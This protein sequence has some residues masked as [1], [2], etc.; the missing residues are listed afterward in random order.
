MAK[1]KPAKGKKKTKKS[2]GSEP[3]HTDL[4]RAGEQAEQPAPMA[5][6]TMS[7]VSQKHI[8]VAKTPWI[9]S[10]EDFDI[11]AF[12]R[13]YTGVVDL[14][15]VLLPTFGGRIC[16]I[17]DESTGKTTTTHILEAAAQKTCRHCFLPIL[18]W[19]NDETGEIIKRCACGKNEPMIVVLIEAE[20]AFD[21]AWAQIWGVDV[22]EKIENKKGFKLRSNKSENF[23]VALP[24]EGDA[25][26][27]F[28][29]DAIIRGAAD[30]VV[31]DSL[32][33]LV[34]KESFQDGQGKDRAVGDTRMSPLAR[35]VASGVARL[36]RA[37]INAKL[38][39]NSRAMLVWTNQY[40]LGPVR[41]PHQDPRRPVGG[42]RAKYAETT[43][44]RINSFQLEKS[45]GLGA[46][47]ASRYADVTFEVFKQKM[48]NIPRGVGSFRIHMADVQ[49]KHGLIRAGQTDEADRL[50]AYLSDLGYYKKE[51]AGHVCLGRTFKKVSDMRD[52]LLRPDVNYAARYLI[53]REKISP[54]G[55]AH[56]FKED[57]GYGPWGPPT[58]LK[59][60]EEDVP[61]SSEEPVPAAGDRGKAEDSSWED[62]MFQ[63]EGDQQGEPEAG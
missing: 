47:K 42:K 36:T 60:Y 2:A 10:P 29:E 44:M 38:K 9:L 20:D 17:G 52:F 12:H 37:Q 27:T 33:M 13:L 51:G 57:Y 21:P 14:D 31:V 6:A 24:T 16:I 22:G 34:P 46:D 62:E 45:T 61:G 28:A 54:S 23:W 55:R 3:V 8:E 19:V 43:V 15:I 56:L 35:L 40:Y 7:E 25:A 32:A 5:R 30:L 26:F 63:S 58:V 4:D 41:N 59:G 50:F 18:E 1:R 39:F 49:T 11:F 53:I 48:G